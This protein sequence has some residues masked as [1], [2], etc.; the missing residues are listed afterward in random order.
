MNEMSLT[1]KRSRAGSPS[2]SPSRSFEMNK[3]Q[4]T[5]LYP[6]GKGGFGKVWKV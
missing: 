5:V 6:I 1:R 2:K 3:K 4:L